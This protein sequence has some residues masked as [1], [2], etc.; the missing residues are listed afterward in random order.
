MTNPSFTE[1]GVAEPLR[2]ALEAEGYTQPTPIQVQAIP[3]LLAGQDLL[4]LAQ[5]GTGKTAAFSLPLLQRLSTGHE[6]RRPRSVRGLILAPTRELAIQI[7]DSLRTYGRHLHLRTTVIV[8]GVGQQPQIKAVSG[9]V[10]ILVATP[11]RLL[12]LV[13]QGHIRLDA[14]TSLVL[15]EADRMFDM[16]FIRDIRKIVAAM[17]KKRHSMLFSATMPA[18]VELLAQ[19]ILHQPA[20]IDVSPPKRTAENIDQRVYFVPAG[21]KRALLS[22]L[23]KD[24]AFER[25]LVFTRTKHVANRVA[26]HLGKSGFAADAIHGNKSQGARQRALE[27]FRSGDAR[28]LVATDIAARGIDVDNVT[29]VVNFELPNEPENYVH[30]IGRT[31][32]A[33]AA[34]IA[35]AFCDPAENGYLRDIERLTRLP[36]TVMQGEAGADQAKPERDY[37]RKAPFRGK[38]GK[39]GRGNNGARRAA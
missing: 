26:E 31:A 1:L 2:R 16:G 17:P 39:R 35:I 6:Q 21:E 20:R 10:D 14:V 27:R 18:D 3:V 34:G 29:H 7:H 37:A 30:R 19:A 15:D 32:R 8:G 23:L 36:L 13:T 33:G 38:R 24:S 11:G 22:A 4:G 9:G 28:V 25:V 12:D 5:T